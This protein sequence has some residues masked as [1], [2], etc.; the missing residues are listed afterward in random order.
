MEDGVVHPDVYDVT[1]VLSVHDD[2]I[3]LQVISYRSDLALGLLFQCDPSRAAT[4]VGLHL[5][6]TLSFRALA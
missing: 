2:F 3:Y 1:S 4:R 5:D 6:Q